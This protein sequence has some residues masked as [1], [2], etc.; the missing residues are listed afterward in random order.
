MYVLYQKRF[1]SADPGG[2]ISQ[3]L[4]FEIMHSP[5]YR[6]SENDLTKFVSHENNL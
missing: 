3:Q 2:T 1:D 6:V 4:Q 5:Q